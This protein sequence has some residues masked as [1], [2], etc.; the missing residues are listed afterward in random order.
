MV[1]LT[2]GSRKIKINSSENWSIMSLA[3][4]IRLQPRDM[5]L[6]LLI[7]YKINALDIKKYV[8]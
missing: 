8:S 4:T 5:D 3:H 7:F 2:A 6:V 1:T